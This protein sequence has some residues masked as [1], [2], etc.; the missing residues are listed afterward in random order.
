M[1]IQTSMYVCSCVL[2]YL[3]GSSLPQSPS[4]CHQYPHIKQSKYTVKSI[5]E[6]IFFYCRLTQHMSEAEMPSYSV[7]YLWTSKLTMC[8]ILVIIFSQT[9]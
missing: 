5:Y 3:S 4:Y 7:L 9:T 8:I 2:R 1:H 6:F